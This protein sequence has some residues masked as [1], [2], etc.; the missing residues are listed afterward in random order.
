MDIQTVCSLRLNIIE[1]RFRFPRDFFGDL[2]LFHA[3]N[4]KFLEKHPDYFLSQFKQVRGI[5]LVC[6]YFGCAFWHPLSKW[7]ERQILKNINFSTPKKA[8]PL[9]T[10]EGVIKNIW[11]GLIFDR[12]RCLPSERSFYNVEIIKESKTRMGVLPKSHH[13]Q[14]NLQQ[15]MP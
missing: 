14:K 5:F 1:F 3:K 13:R 15:S 8:F 6:G 11:Q 7:V 12:F 9:L 4:W 2:F 10:S